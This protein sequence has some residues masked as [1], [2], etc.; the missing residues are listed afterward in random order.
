VVVDEVV[1]DEDKCDERCQQQTHGSHDVV[2]GSIGHG[3]SISVVH[4]PQQQGY[5]VAQRATV[6]TV[7]YVVM[8]HVQIVAPRCC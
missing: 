5:T 1:E 7:V 3:D 4:T 2:H 6:H 8:D